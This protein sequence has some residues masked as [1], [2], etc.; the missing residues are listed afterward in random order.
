MNTFIYYIAER[1]PGQGEMQ[2]FAHPIHVGIVTADDVMDAYARVLEDLR[3]TFADSPQP[4]EIRFE[5][6]SPPTEPNPQYFDPRSDS[7]LPEWIP[8]H[9][10]WKHNMPIDMDITFTASD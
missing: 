7:G 1:I 5:Q 6:M 2:R 10:V 9:G 3:P 8:T 4:L